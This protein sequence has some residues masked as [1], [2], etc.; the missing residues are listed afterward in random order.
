MTAISKN[1]YIDATDIAV[2]ASLQGDAKMP[3]AAI[4][5]R[6]GLS[7]AAVNERIRK[8]EARGVIRRYAALLDE[9]AVGLGITAFVEVSIERPRHERA[10]VA[11]MER[12]DEVMECHYV[13]GE[14]SCLLKVRV[15]DR[16]ALRTLLLDRI[17]AHEGVRQ[18][19]T[20]MVLETAKETPAM[21]LGSAGSDGASGKN[22]AAARQRRKR[23]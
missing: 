10:F 12:L 13:T 18:T 21:P 22:G 9:A 4:A 14:F 23:G 5:R 8:L 7:V 20:L 3:Q 15:A 16:Q 11:L 19:R 1:F 17:N 2:L 6:V